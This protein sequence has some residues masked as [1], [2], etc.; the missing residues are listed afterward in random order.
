LEVLENRI[1]A[2]MQLSTFFMTW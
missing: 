2:T 1:E